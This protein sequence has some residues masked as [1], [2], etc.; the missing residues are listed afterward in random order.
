MS[1]TPSGRGRMLAGELYIAADPELAQQSAR[2]ER[3]PSAQH[4]D[5]ADTTRHREI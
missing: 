1:E 5:P 3:D 4:V 2:A